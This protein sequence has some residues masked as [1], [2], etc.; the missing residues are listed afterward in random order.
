LHSRAQIPV[1]PPHPIPIK[2][3]WHHPPSPLARH[4]STESLPRTAD[5]VI[6]GSGITGA[7]VAWNLL[8]KGVKDIVMLEARD[9]VGGATGRNGGHTKAASYRTYPSHV[10]SHSPSTAAK[11]ARLELANIRDTHAFASTHLIACTSRPCQT[12]DIIYDPATY[13]SGID[14]IHTLQ[15][16]LG[17]ADAAA[18]YKILDAEKTVTK[19]LVGPEKAPGGIHA[20]EKVDGAFAYEAGSINAYAFTS[21]VLSLCISRGMTLYTHT[22][23]T[24][25][26]ASWP[27]PAQDFRY[28]VPTAQG[29]INARRVVLATNGY[30]ANLLPSLQSIIVPLR[31]QIAA[32]KVPQGSTLP[33]LLP[34]TYSFMYDGGYDYMI[35]RL[36]TSSNS[37]GTGREEQ[38]I[39]IGGGLGRL[40]SSGAS[41]YGTV[42]DSELNPATSE[43]LADIGRAYFGKH[44]TGYRGGGDDGDDVVREWTGIMGVTPDD[45]PFIGEVPM[46]LVFE[47][48]AQNQV[49]ERSRN[50]SSGL[51]IAAGFNGHGM[52]LALKC[53]EA[54]ADLM[55]SGDAAIPQWFP[56]EFLISDDRIQK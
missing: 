22:P 45:M 31:G 37:D 15:S 7:M 48:A 41:E 10:L 39:I 47:G 16:N 49:G 5:T 35:P 14:A 4:R 1:Q 18:S 40:P 24:G 51:F 20:P 12:T 3:Y 13:T 2:S 21:G 6:I 23:V 9:A 42:D 34:S 26:I 36:S 29:T 54:L 11:I 43:Y 27:S 30:T 50:G 8:E 56:R 19:F 17:A 38:H 33:T 52:A 55:Q 53:A 25:V 28:A 46:P 32:L 44:W